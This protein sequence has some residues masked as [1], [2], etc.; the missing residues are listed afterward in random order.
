MSQQAHLFINQS[1]QGI[2]I[3]DGILPMN[4]KVGIGKGSGLLF[5]ITLHIVY[6]TCSF[7]VFVV[8]LTCLSKIQGNFNNK[9]SF[10]SEKF[11]KHHIIRYPII[12]D[13][14]ASDPGD[15]NMNVC[16]Q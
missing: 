4:V 9:I 7:F 10:F 11:L 2:D 12:V 5:L 14:E 3:I 6:C 1:I 16:S 15:I 13:R 8:K